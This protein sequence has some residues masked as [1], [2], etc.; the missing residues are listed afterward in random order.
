[1]EKNEYIILHTVD[2][3]CWTGTVVILS[4]Y[5]FAYLLEYI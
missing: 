1:M 4:F 3:E 2:L 5:Y